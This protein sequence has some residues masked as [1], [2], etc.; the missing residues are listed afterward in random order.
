MTLV[1]IDVALSVL[2]RRSTRPAQ[3]LEGVP[4]MIVV[5]GRP[6][7][8]RMARARVD[9]HGVLVAVRGRHGLERMDQITYAVLERGGGISIVPRRGDAPGAPRRA[10]SRPSVRASAT[11]NARASLLK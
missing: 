3:W 5:H 10:S 7:E 4:R 1:G 11:A 2:K 9:A 6:L 8:D